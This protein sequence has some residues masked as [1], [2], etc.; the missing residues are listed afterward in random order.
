MLGLGRRRR[1]PHSPRRSLPAIVGILLVLAVGNL[2]VASG[3]PRGP[4]AECGH[5][6]RA[7][8]DF[9]FGFKAGVS[10]AQHTGT[11]E[12]EPDYEV[13]SSW[14]TGVTA[15]AFLYF[16]VTSR[17]GL[18]QEFAYTQKGSRQD[19]GVDIL[20]IPTVLDVTYDM[21]YIEIQ[22][23]LRFAWLQW[24]GK[25]LYSLSG[26]ALCLKVR[27]CYS[28]RG[29]VS[30]EIQTVP[31]YADDDMSEVDMFDFALVYGTGF[32]LPLAGQ[33]LQLEYRF[34]M[35]WNTLAMPTY[36][37]V[38]FGDEDVLIDNEPVPLKN[39]NHLIL[40]GLRF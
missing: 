13:S 38:P 27:D 35:A 26:T 9:S 11:E 24:A 3:Q 36:A 28:L 32:E 4:G 22:A 8:T 12:R 10:F 1:S 31:I 19:I 29:E 20:E 16:P 23:L 25:E 21:D 5:A 14:R 7:F 17:F 39:Q 15:S 6:E 2:G 34:T 30:D 40:V 37:Y 18:Q 33:R